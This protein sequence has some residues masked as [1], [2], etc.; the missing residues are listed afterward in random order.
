M[1]IFQSVLF[2]LMQKYSSSCK[3]KR[4]NGEED[5]R[6]RDKVFSSSFFF[7]LSSLKHSRVD[8]YIHFNTRNKQVQIIK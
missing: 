8:R 1:E 5:E 6:E 4:K 7:S 2:N 3:Q